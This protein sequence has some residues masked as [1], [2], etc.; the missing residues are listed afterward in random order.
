MYDITVRSVGATPVYVPLTALTIDLSALEKSITP[1]TRMI[2]VCN[3]NNPTGTVVSRNDMA[4]FLDH[5]R[6]D[7]VVVMDEAYLEFIRD[8]NAA[9]V[10]GFF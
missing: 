5:L 2:F 6:E 9:P 1:A 3:P 4:R 8:P 7:I 10:R